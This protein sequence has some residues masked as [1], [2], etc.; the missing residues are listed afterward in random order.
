MAERPEQALREWHRVRRERDETYMADV[1]AETGTGER[2]ATDVEGG[3]YE[4]V[5]LAFMAAVMRGE[6]TSMILD[7]RNGGA[8]P[9]LPAD[10]VVEVPCHVDGA[11]ARPLAA[12]PL[13]GHQ[14]GLLQQVKAVE[15]LVIEA[16][17]TGDG[18]A[19]P[20]AFALHPMVDS[21]TTARRLLDGYRTS[22]PGLKGLI[23]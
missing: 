8:V 3:G 7:V 13:K 17:L 6:Q 11:G 16:A 12:D 2:E 4:G 10:A 14:I 18:T 19:A 5:A 21:V 9:G 22:H 15:R 20:K 1:R 23:R